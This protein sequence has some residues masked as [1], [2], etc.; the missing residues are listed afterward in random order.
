MPDA[1][2]VN[3]SI[4]SEAIILNLQKCVFE[5]LDLGWPLFLQ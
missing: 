3:I 2:Y 5:L 4:S 1:T